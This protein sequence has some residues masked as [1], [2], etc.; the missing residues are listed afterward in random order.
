MGAAV[1]AARRVT[2][3]LARRAW[4]ACIGYRRYRYERSH[5]TRLSPFDSMPV[6]D[7]VEIANK[8]LNPYGFLAAP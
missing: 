2:R 1:P 6:G 5:P 8:C 7:A 4:I 3:A